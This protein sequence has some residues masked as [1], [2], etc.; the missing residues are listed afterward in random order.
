MIVD[1]MENLP[2]YAGLHA[3]LD[4]LIAR[5]RT[6]APSALRDGDHEVVPG[7]VFLRLGY[8]SAS[9]GRDWRSADGFELRLTLSG[10]QR[11]EYAA[12]EGD[13]A[14]AEPAGA[15]TLKPGSFA[16]F[17]PGERHR[18][19]ECAPGTRDAQYVVDTRL[20]AQ[21]GPSP[22][23]HCGTRELRTPRLLLRR[24]REGDE[25]AMFRNWCSDPEVTRTL[26]WP[27]HTGVDV[28]RRIL[29]GWVAAYR[30]ERSY[31]WAVAADGEPIGDI[32][33]N[34]HSDENMDCEIGYCLGRKYWNQGLMTE[35][36]RRVAEFLFAEVGFHRVTL[37]HDA[38]NPASG[39]VMQKAGFRLEGVLRE[40]LKRKD[41]TFG[42]ALLYA[43]LAHE[44]TGNG[45]F[46]PTDPR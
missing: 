2:E 38:Q 34:H 39:R 10:W 8:A 9:Q 30:S 44:W 13:D 45:D 3:N 21:E 43:A 22:L 33:V 11:F 24:F 46:P 1:R 17:L 28:T 42:D 19:A 40:S 5:A 37:R 23:R 27:T 29:A 14:A 16:L 18:M 12:G 32:A 41:G 7:T 20:R 26:Q 31:H 36:L 15:F 6:L 25:W 4:A 35:A